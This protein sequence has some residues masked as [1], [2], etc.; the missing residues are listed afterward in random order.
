[1]GKIQRVMDFFNKGLNFHIIPVLLILFTFFLNNR[2]YAQCPEFSLKNTNID[3]NEAR[4][5]ISISTSV[6]INFSL[7]RVMLYDFNEAKFYFDSDHRE[8]VTEIRGLNVRI[9]TNRIESRG[10]PAGDFGI[11]IE[12]QGCQKQVIGSGYSGFPNSAIKIDK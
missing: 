4:G 10:L 2:L 7:V 11:V 8:N 5:N 1:M 3:V 6:N 12:K 9:Y